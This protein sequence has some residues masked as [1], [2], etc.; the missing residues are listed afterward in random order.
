VIG[1][2]TNILVRYIVQDSDE[3]ELATVFLEKNCSNDTPGFLCLV[4]LCELVWVLRKAYRYDKSVVTKILY[5]LLTTAEIEI[6]NTLVA[7]RAYQDYQDGHADFSDY[8][9]AHIC[10]QRDTDSVITFD[11]K[12]ARHS[13]FTLLS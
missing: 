11:K 6:E 10:H 2:D 9:I 3:S 13:L 12:A 4:V 1:I 7:W 8:L 5:K